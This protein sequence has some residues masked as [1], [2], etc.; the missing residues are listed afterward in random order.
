MEALTAYS[1]DEDES[2]GGNNE[3]QTPEIDPT[4][5]SEVVAKLKEKFPLDSAPHVPIRVSFLN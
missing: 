3:S 4:R 2:K 1:S 5:T